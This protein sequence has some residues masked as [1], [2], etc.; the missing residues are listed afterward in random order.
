MRIA[1]AACLSLLAA[2]PA[3]AVDI[4][5]VTSPGGIHAWLVEEHSIPFTALELRFE[6]GTALDAPGKR[7]ATLLM[8]AT[9]EEG[10][11]DL[12]SQQ[13]A[14]ARER[15]AAS[16]SFDAYDDAAT[17]SV[18]M[19]TE[20]RDRAVALLKQALT[21]PRFDA[22][23]IERVKGQVSS[24]IRSDATDPNK[25][26]TRAFDV[27]AFGDH[28]YGSSRFGTLDSLAGLTRDDLVA[29]KAAVLAR[30]RIFVSA[31]GDITPDQLGIMLD[32]LLGGLPATGAPMPP[33]ADLGLEGGVSVIDFASPQSVVLFGA[34]GIKRDDPDFFA[35]YILNHI[36]GGGGFA[37]RLMDE[38]REK[39]GLTYGVSTWLAPMDLAEIW[40][41]S[42]SSANEKVA[43]AITVVRDVW[44]DV[45]ANGVTEA[46]LEA[47]K[48][49]LTGSYP[50][51]FD[52]NGPIANMLVGLQAER[53][54]MSYVNDR[55]AY[56]E[57]VT[58]ADIRRVAQRLMDA[59]ALRFVVVGQPVG[60]AATD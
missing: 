29:A 4:Q 47:A 17:V 59:D 15:L 8:M 52:G 1:L 24:I 36:L 28:P 14:E 34:G 9:L 30:D 5:E 2:L 18:Q 35:A 12:D 20:N 32:D 38:V 51:R 13:F 50:L 37:S 25:I 54:P 10:S 40:Q 26:A 42:F 11:G 46:E 21:A 43:E 60:V 33:R 53:L 7:G 3:R 49:Y 44:T 31:V 56:I 16:F 23:S 39:R 58:L 41:G 57:A 27:Q 6:G 48:T 55:N 22:A 19:L 45:A